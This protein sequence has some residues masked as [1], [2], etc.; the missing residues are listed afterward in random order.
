M[1]QQQVWKLVTVIGA[2]ILAAGIYLG[3]SAAVKVADGQLGADNCGSAFVANPRVES[4]ACDSK[5]Q[6][7]RTIAVMLMLLGGG[8]G[9]Y[10]LAQ[11]PT[12]R[13]WGGEAA[14]GAARAGQ[15]ETP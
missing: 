14:P 2:A 13:P 11:V 8:V 5:R 10:A 4:A 6:D 1:P 7:R 15:A 3:F 12:W 9:G